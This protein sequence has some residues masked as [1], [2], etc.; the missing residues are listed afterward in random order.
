[1]TDQSLW[2]CAVIGGIL[3]LAH[4]PPAAHGE[5]AA[6][7]AVNSGVQEVVATPERS[8]G[9]GEAYFI[10]QR[11]EF[12]SPAWPESH[13]QYSV[14][15]CNP[16]FTAQ[17]LS[18]LRRTRPEAV[19]LAYTNAQDV[20]IGMYES[21]YYRALTAVFDSS[22]C[23]RDASSGEVIRLYDPDPVVHPERGQPGFVMH[24]HSAELLAS[25]LAGVTMRAGWD[26]LYVDQCTRV[27]P[28]HRRQMLARR[29]GGFDFDA[30]GR[31][32]TLEEGDA[33]YER[34]RP[35]FTQ[36]LREELGDDALII[37]NSGG[38]LRDPALN[39]ISLEDPGVRFDPRSAE[40]YLAGQHEVAARP[41][42]SIVWVKSP[43]SGPPSRELAAALDGVSV[44]RL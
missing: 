42:L 41:R 15:V 5:Q 40:R 33:S 30:D 2:K 14:F 31:A 9:F 37:G 26:G 20:P 36:R 39:G 3:I 38:A 43:G 12:R 17:D 11:A 34:W 8:A 27:F 1:M 21:S 25:F 35:H 28:E 18:R 29:A 10:L 7:H 13:E 22:F 44:G 4:S 32:D 19:F 23:V 6:D 16:S 24:R